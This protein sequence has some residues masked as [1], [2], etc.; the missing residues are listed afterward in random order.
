MQDV[1]TEQ[2][3]KE[4]VETLFLKLEERGGIMKPTIDELGYVEQMRQ[5]L[6]LNFDDTSRDREIEDM[7]PFQRVQ[8]I[9]GWLHG[10]PAWA[11]EYKSYFESQG[12][13]LTTDPEANGIF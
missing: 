9:V 13:Y 6:G 1:G 3:L 11:D 4:M 12:I 8:L 10:D 2:A 7:D 5:R